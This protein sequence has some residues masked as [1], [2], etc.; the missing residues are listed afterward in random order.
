M[1]GPIILVTQDEHGFTHLRCALDL[2]AAYAEDWVAEVSYARGPF[3]GL[4]VDL[5]DV[6][7]DVLDDFCG[8]AKDELRSNP[9]MDLSHLTT[10]HYEDGEIV[11]NAEPVPEVAA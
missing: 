4:R 3:G 10:H 6:P 7:E 11:P 5:H 1:S 2:D 9:R 8:V